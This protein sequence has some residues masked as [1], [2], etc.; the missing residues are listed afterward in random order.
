MSDM[1]FQRYQ[2]Q[3]VGHVRAPRTAPRPKG[4]SSRGMRVY[5]EIAF[6][7]MEETLAACFP[8]SKSVLG[9]RCWHRLVR[10]FIAGHRCRTPLFREIPQEF[11][12]YLEGG[13][14]ETELP[15]FLQ[16]LAHYEW[17]ELAL[18]LSDEELPDTAYA[19][20]GDLLEERPVLAPA[21]AL[22]RYDYAV[23]RIGPRYKPTAPD[24]EPTYILAFRRH[25]DEVKFIVLNPVSVRLVALLQEG[26]RGAAALRQIA[27]E[28]Q[29]P[30]PDA[31]MRSGVEILQNLRAEQAIW[32]SRS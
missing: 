25:D 1:A 5:A 13:D 32:G 4:T 10:A 17:V 8:V 20:D 30:D 31:V 18:A 22:L 23:Q 16:S 24:A 19:P 12:R 14:A 9:S 6:A 7:N 11:L 28:L 29:H 2:A 27:A 21:L 15:P 26:L 3:F